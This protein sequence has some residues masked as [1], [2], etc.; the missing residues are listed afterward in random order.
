MRA[1]SVGGERV[2]LALDVGGTTIEAAVVGSGGALRGEV[3]R[4]ASPAGADAAAILACLAGL[5][6]QLR[7][8]AEAAGQRPV[9]AGL[10]MPGPFDYPRGVSQMRHKLAAV[11]GLDLRA[12][13][14]A[15]VELPVRF[16]NDATAFAVGAWWHEHADEPRLVGV[17][18]GTGVGSGFVVTGRPVGAEEGAPAG[19][20]VWDFPFRGG[21]LEDAVSRRAVS[22][23]YERRSGEALEVSEIA[24]RAR[25]GDVAALE[26]F[27]QLGDALGEGL[28]SAAALFGPTRVV[29]GGQLARTFDLFGSCAQDAYGRLTGTDVVF[30][31]AVSPHLAL[32]GVARCLAWEQPL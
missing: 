31:A 1:R 6:T 30:S 5:L 27:G 4:L 12:P 32:L 17:T 16:I 13:L 24:R 19:G 21:I 18:V 20:E 2:M 22:R 9:A 14:E 28:G 25:T 11:R 3:L 8:S 15:A 10:G 7:R 29:C 23:S 26:A